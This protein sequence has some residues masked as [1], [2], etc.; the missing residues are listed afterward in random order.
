MKPE[1]LDSPREW[2][3]REGKLQDEEEVIEFFWPAMGN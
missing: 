1:S 2:L 3:D